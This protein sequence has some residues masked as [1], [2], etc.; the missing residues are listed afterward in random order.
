NESAMPYAQAAPSRYGMSPA[1]R[2]N[3]YRTSANTR[4]RLAPGAREVEV[5]GAT[6]IASDVNPLVQRPGAPRILRQLLDEIDN[7]RVVPGAAEV[8]P[9]L[10]ER[11]LSQV[12]ADERQRVDELHEAV[13]Q[14][15]EQR[16]GML[17]PVAQ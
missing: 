4:R 11:L 3:R 8:R 5:C 15:D 17:Q 13:G 2:K 7:A 16:R 9:H 14:D 6:I 1:Y 12:P 10:E